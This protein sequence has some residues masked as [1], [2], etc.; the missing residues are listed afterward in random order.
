MPLITFLNPNEIIENKFAEIVSIPSKFLEKLKDQNRRMEFLDDPN[1]FFSIIHIPEYNKQDKLI[2]Q[3]E[4]DVC[5]EKSKN[6]GYLFFDN[7]NNFAI[8]YQQNINSITYSNYAELLFEIYKLIQEDE[9]KIIDHILSDTNTIKDEYY[10]RLSADVLIRHLTNNQI[11]ISGLKLILS[12]QIKFL[13][14]SKQYLKHSAYQILMYR[15]TE[16]KDE[17]NYANEFS[18]TLMNSMNTKFE[19][20]TSNDIYFW[21]KYTFIAIVGTFFFDILSIFI[22]HSNYAWFAWAIGVTACIILIVYTLYN[23]K[24]D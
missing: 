7:T 4:L 2:K 12:N 23:F 24:K 21:T 17:L 19:V 3:I 6:Q 15:Q 14:Y 8:R 20:K 5:Y 22:S 13:E 16:I 10:A 18:G 9:I 1:F 11:N